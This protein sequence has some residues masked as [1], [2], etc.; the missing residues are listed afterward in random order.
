MKLIP[1]IS[2]M[3]SRIAVVEDARYQFLRTDG[4]KFRSPTKLVQELPGDEVFIIDIDGLERSAPNLKTIKKMAAY[5]NIWLDA[6]TEDAHDMM[7]LFINDAELAVLGTK[8]LYNLGEL[9]EA[10]ELSDKVIFSIDYDGGIISPDKNIA[11][12]DIGQ[13]VESVKGFKDLDTVIFMDLGSHRDKTPVDIGM[14]A[15]LIETFE[16]LY[17]SA[18]VIP[19]DYQNLEEAGI[20]GLIIDFRT[21]GDES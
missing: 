17:L 2:I 7:D 20:T 5:K 8:S 11:G 6:G 15:P 21:I 16:N 13:L 18:Y 4:G 19:E 14:L 9:E 12:M 3:D 10:T 1:A